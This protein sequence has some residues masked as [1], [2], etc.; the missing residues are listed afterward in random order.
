MSKAR[1]RS[2]KMQVI[3]TLSGFSSIPA[4]CFGLQSAFCPD[5]QRIRV[6]DHATVALLS[7]HPERKSEGSGDRL[8][9]ADAA[10]RHDATGGRRHLCLAAARLSRAEEDRADR[11][12]GAGP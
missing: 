2:N 12:R 11:A 7:S 9:P 10:R 6:L 4:L 5:L 1:G 3:R 8:A